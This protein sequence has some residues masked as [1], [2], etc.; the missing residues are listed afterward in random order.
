MGRVGTWTMRDRRAR[1][2][3]HLNIGSIYPDAMNAERAP[4]DH[5]QL[6]EVLHGGQVARLDGDPAGAQRLRE[7]SLAISDQ[8]RLLLR[9]RKVQCDGKVFAAPEVGHRLVQRPAHGVRRMRWDAQDKWRICM[10]PKLTNCCLQDSRAGR[11]FRQFSS[12]HLMVHH[13]ATANLEQG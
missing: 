11:T 9:F 2:T 4:L 6:H 13:T 12:K 5:A 1:L 10:M 8:C 7:R 3:E